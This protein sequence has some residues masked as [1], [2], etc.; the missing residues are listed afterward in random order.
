MKENRLKENK[1]KRNRRKILLAKK[2]IGLLFLKVS[3]TK[4]IISSVAFTTECL[5]LDLF[6]N[7]LKTIDKHQ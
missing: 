7:L 2:T 1:E 5:K 6:K 3:R 4:F